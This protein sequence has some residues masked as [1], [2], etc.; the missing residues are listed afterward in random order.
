MCGETFIQ[1]NFEGALTLKV[2]LENL[3]LQIIAEIKNLIFNEINSS[4]PI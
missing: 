1:P 4:K 2:E 3:K